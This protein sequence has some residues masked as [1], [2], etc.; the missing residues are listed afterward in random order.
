[1]IKNKKILFL[2]GG[3][4]NT[5][6]TYT[7]YLL[8][9]YFTD[10]RLS[11]FISYL[12]GIIFAFYF[13]SK[14]VFNESFSWKL[15]FQYP[16]VYIIQYIASALLL[17]LLVDEITI[18]KSIALLIVITMMVPFSYLLNDLIFKKQKFERENLS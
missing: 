5:V 3:L 15:L 13:N 14:Y 9:N 12:I 16:L 2:F 4:L 8:L 1:M 7:I 18:D 6:L 11:Y 17:T 10:Y